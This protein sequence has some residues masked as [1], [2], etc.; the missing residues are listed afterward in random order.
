MNFNADKNICKISCSVLCFWIEHYVNNQ[1]KIVPNMGSVQY[2]PIPEVI[3]KQ[4]FYNETKEEIHFQI[5]G[6]QYSCT[7]K[8][9][10]HIFGILLLG[11][12]YFIFSLVPKLKKFK[13]RKCDLRSATILLS[14]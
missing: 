14:K 10:Y 3:N 7:R 4:D 13:Y 6:F 11:V 9:F 1:Q 8:L 5:Y 12:P 2:V